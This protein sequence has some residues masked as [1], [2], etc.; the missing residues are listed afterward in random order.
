MLQLDSGTAD[1]LGRRLRK[2]TDRLGVV[3]ELDVLLILVEELQESGRYEERAL[4]PVAAALAD[5]QATAR[6][7]LLARLPVAQLERLAAKMD[8]I[9]DDLAGKEKTQRGG[10]RG[11][12][13]AI[14]ARVAHRA[15]ALKSAIQNAGAVY[16]PDRVHQVRIAMKKFR[17]AV[18][19]EAEVSDDKTWTAMLATLKRT[20]ELLGRLHD[21]QI[22]V[23]RIRTV[24]ASLTPPDLVV[25]RGLDALVIAIEKE[26]RRIH[27]RYVRD[28]DVLLDVCDRV[29]V[30]KPAARPAR[31]A[32]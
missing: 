21:R 10:V 29:A 1:R 24:Q 30:R 12:K 6:D 22:L 23:E 4:A 14:D 18:E 3:R 15:S 5:Q 17:Y 32:S 31:R 19:L 26:C 9:A 16:L 20:Q 7:K 25:W 2:V 27:A 28:T 11:W 8:R 13:W